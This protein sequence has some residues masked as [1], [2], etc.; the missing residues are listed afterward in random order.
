MVKR[1]ADS[2]VWTLIVLAFF[3][4]AL[5]LEINLPALW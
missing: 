3:L 2:L 4:A 1:I 5:V